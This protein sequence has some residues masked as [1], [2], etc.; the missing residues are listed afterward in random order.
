MVS[1]DCPVAI[2]HFKKNLFYVID[3]VPFKAINWE[4]I[5]WKRFQTRFDV[6]FLVQKRL[7]FHE[8]SENNADRFHQAVAH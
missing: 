1:K 8:E 3:I 7:S 6:H 4:A 5:K 2:V